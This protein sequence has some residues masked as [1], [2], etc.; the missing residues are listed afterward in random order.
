MS[1]LYTVKI[2]NILNKHL[3]YIFSVYFY[4]SD[5]VL[6]FCDFYKILFFLIISMNIS[7]CSIS[8]M[9]FFFI[10]LLSIIIHLFFQ[11]LF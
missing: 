7:E 4:F 8:V 11:F 6:C 9:Y 3:F 10:F 2:L 1:V 5:F